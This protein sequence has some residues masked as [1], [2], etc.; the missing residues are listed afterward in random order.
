MWTTVTGHAAAATT[1]NTDGGRVAVRQHVAR[2]IDVRLLAGLALVAVSAVAGAM[3]LGRDQDT[4]TVWRA[5]RDLS[6]GSA[7]LDAEPVAIPRSSVSDQ[8]L[9][10][11]DGEVG[12]LARP[13]S[14]GELVPRSAVAAGAQRP[15]RQVTVPVDPLHAPPGLLPGDAVDVWASGG[16][17]SA[18]PPQLV[19]AGVTVADVADDDTGLSG[20]LGVV[21]SVPE[22]AVAEVVAATRAG[23]LDLVAV[24]IDSQAVAGGGSA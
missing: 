9:G 11:A 24:P 1:T 8:Y 7:L 3:L 5:T 15:L 17:A 16:E 4:V 12:T 13:V 10:P 19:L 21:L 2:V 18:T 23:E 6:I 20:R 22:D 14:A